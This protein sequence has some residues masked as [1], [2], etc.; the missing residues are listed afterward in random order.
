MIEELLKWQNEE[1]Y[2]KLDKLLRRE[3]SNIKEEKR[4]KA[5]LDYINNSNYCFIANIDNDVILTNNDSLYIFDNSINI[6]NCDKLEY[7]NRN[8]MIRILNYYKKIFKNYNDVYIY[9]LDLFDDNL[10]INNISILTSYI[11]NALDILGYQDLEFNLSVDYPVLKVKTRKGE[12]YIKGI[13][14]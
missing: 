4:K 10:N 8:M 6:P 7:V 14:R 2:K 9:Q 1:K 3:I 12:S 5:I 13:W 11:I